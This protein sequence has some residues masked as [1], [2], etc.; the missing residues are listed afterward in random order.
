M[1]EI[2]LIG[3]KDFGFNLNWNRPFEHGEIEIYDGE[4]FGEDDMAR[5]GFNRNK[6]IKYK[7]KKR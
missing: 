3:F 7:R 4:T 1:V 5:P 2:E 6:C